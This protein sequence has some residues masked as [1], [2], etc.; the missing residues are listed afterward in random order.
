MWLVLLNTFALF[1]MI[2][3]SAAWLNRPRTALSVTIAQPLRFAW[4]MIRDL[5]SARLSPVILALPDSRESP[6]TW[7]RSVAE[8]TSA[9]HAAPVCDRL[10]SLCTKPPRSPA[11]TPCSGMSRSARMRNRVGV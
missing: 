8:A 4:S 3:E 9:I 2:A 7:L 5:P 10:R 11:F 6:P 1:R